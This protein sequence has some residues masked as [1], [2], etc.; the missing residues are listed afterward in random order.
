MK[1]NWYRLK[2]LWQFIFFVSSYSGF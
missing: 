1:S 2:K